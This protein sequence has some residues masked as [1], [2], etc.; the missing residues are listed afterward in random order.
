MDTQEFRLH[1]CPYCHYAGFGMDFD[2]DGDIPKGQALEHVRDALSKNKA[3]MP[4]GGLW[5]LERM[6]AAEI[7]LLAREAPADRLEQLYRLGAWLADDAGED[8]MA[9]EYRHKAAQQLMAAAGLSE[10]EG[11]DYVAGIDAY[12]SG[13]FAAALAPFKAAR[14]ALEVQ[15]RAQ[16]PQW[17]RVRDAILKRITATN[18]VADSAPQTRPSPDAEDDP[19]LDYHTLVDAATADER[20]VVR[21][22]LSGRRLAAAIDWLQRLAELGLQGPDASYQKAKAGA[23]ADRRDFVLVFGRRPTPAIAQ[24]ITSLANSDSKDAEGR[25]SFYLLMLQSQVGAD[26]ARPPTIDVPK[27]VKDLAVAD[28]R[29]SAIGALVQART[30]ETAS[31]LLTDLPAHPD[32]YSNFPLAGE[33]QSDAWQ[34]MAL[35]SAGAMKVAQTAWANLKPGQADLVAQ[36]ALRPLA[37]CGDDP[38]LDLLRAATA[39]A[40]HPTMR[41]EAAYCLIVREKHEGAAAFMSLAV[42]DDD[43]LPAAETDLAAKF[44]TLITSADIPELLKIRQRW[45]GPIQRKNDDRR[46]MAAVLVR[47]ALARADGRQF[48]D[49]YD[50][51]VDELLASDV[52]GVEPARLPWEDTVP[53]RMEMLGWCGNLLFTPH[54]NEQLR[55][56]LR[57]GISG[58]GMSQAIDLLVRANV[59]QDNDLIAEQ[60]T[61]PVPMEVKL[62]LLRA[63]QALHI[64]GQD[65]IVARWAKSARITLVTATQRPAKMP[66]R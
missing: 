20:P 9:L 28:A 39:P 40:V 45:P 46:A 62:S 8:A 41:L 43:I 18:G 24:Q 34:A 52:T 3:T 59:D 48:M 27:Y 12:W 15:I 63:R 42:T 13:N 10:Q 32:D 26:E 7:C 51:A 53:E 66:G 5:P 29:A 38:S 14:P 56:L 1:D 22:R 6:R 57:I 23:F 11:A 35:D 44:V 49:D 65:A 33:R 64:Q 2:P 55:P 19:E 61:R 37:Y 31:A 47:A 58:Y 54:I 21:R 17:R 16:Q 30:L 25:E 4:A 36:L 50:K 60:F